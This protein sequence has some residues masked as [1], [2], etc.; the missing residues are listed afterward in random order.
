MIRHGRPTAHHS[1]GARR[2]SPVRAARCGNPMRAF[3]A[4]PRRWPVIS[5]GRWIIPRP[6]G[7]RRASPVRAAGAASPVALPALRAGWVR[8]AWPPT[9]NGRVLRPPWPTIDYGP[10]IPSR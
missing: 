4:T 2:A 6:V 5:H 3:R 8:H 9:P 1:V 7:A 10:H